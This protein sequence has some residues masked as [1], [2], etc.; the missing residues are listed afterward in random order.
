MTGGK[1]PGLT[2]VDH[3]RTA[4]LLRATLES[5]TD[6]VL[7]V[8]IH[9]AMQTCN[10]RFLDMWRLPPDSRAIGARS[11]RL[12]LMADELKD[13][14]IFYRTLSNLHERRGEENFDTIELKDGRIFERFSKP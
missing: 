13:P 5:T 14:A 12:R 6:G 3:Q 8:D 7:V 1:S 2:E 4:S 11:E 10:Q 9:G